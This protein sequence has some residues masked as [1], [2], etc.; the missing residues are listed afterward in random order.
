V[1]LDGLSPE[2]LASLPVDRRALEILRAVT[3]GED[4]NFFSSRWNVLNQLIQHVWHGTEPAAAR[5]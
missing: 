2:P 3:A 5:A 1:K 4:R